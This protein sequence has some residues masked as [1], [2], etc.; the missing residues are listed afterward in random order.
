MTILPCI[1]HLKTT[2]QPTRKQLKC[3]LNQYTDCTKYDLCTC[4]QILHTKGW[5][6]APKIPFNETSTQTTPVCL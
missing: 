2:P 6:C 4:D 5:L 3:K 1:Q